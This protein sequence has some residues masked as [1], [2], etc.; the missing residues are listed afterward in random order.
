MGL[1]AVAVR[2]VCSSG[3][4]ASGFVPSAPLSSSQSG[5]L[6]LFVRFGEYTG[7]CVLHK[8]F[9][10]QALGSV[11]TWSLH[12]WARSLLLHRSCQN[13]ALWKTVVCLFIDRA[14]SLLILLAFNSAV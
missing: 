12:S 5:T 8:T 3:I 4:L 9:S 7:V 14:S 13:C 6:R 1:A 2:V 11:S 10:P